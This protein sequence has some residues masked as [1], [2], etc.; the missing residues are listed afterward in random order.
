MKNKYIIYLLCIIIAFFLLKEFFSYKINFL[1]LLATSTPIILT[2]KSDENNKKEETKIYRLSNFTFK[3]SEYDEFSE[4][5][6]IEGVP[7]KDMVYIKNPFINYENSGVFISASPTTNCTVFNDN[8]KTLSDYEKDY[9]SYYTTK[10]HS[11][12]KIS[13]N[14]IPM[15]KQV[16]SV[17]I[18]EKDKNGKDI[19]NTDFYI[20]TKEGSRYVFFD[21]ERFITIVG[22]FKYID[23]IANTIELV[24]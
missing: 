13:V 2:E 11:S 21:G 22:N 6:A 19:L 8:A 18:M 20:G 1:S 4:K 5:V 7:C 15:L 10:I 3:Y 14:N 9:K 16:Y 12:E 23:K 24:N 17:G